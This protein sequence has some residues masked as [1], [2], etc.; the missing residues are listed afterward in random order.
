MNVKLR[1][2]K[3]LKYLYLPNL[4]GTQRTK[5]ILSVNPTIIP[6]R[7][8]AKEVIV[9]VFDYDAGSLDEK[10]LSSVD[11]ACKYKASKRVTWLNIDGL[12]KAD[13]DIISEHYGIH[14]LIVEDI[15]SINQRPKMDEVDNVLF[16]LLNMLYYNDEACTVEQEQISIVLGSDFVITFQED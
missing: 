7:E 12:R 5:E 8:E 4:F 3:Y 15:L 2:E 13:I 10:Q 9:Y 16:C 14:P 11:E 1:P 6:Q